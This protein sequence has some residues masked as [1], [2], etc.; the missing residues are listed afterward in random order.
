MQTV[1]SVTMLERITLS[2][3]VSNNSRKD[4]SR[5]IVGLVTIVE[6]VTL[7]KQLGE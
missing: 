2:K 3:R 1:G 5:Q 6:R 7:I 4:K